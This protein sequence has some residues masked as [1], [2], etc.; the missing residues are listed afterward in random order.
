LFNF[1]MLFLRA[2]DAATGAFTRSTLGRGSDRQ[3]RRLFSHTLNKPRYFNKLTAHL[4][5]AALAANLAACG[6][7]VGRPLVAVDEQPSEGSG[8]SG[9]GV[10]GYCDRVT[11]WPEEWEGLENGAWNLVN[12]LRETGVNCSGEPVVPSPPLLNL[13]PALRCAARLHSEDMVV[14]DFFAH[15]NEDGVDYP[16]RIA[17][18][19]YSAPVYGESIA[20]SNEGFGGFGGQVPWSLFQELRAEECENLVDPRFDSVG[21]G[22]YE[23]V[24]T[25]DFAGR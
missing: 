23:G 17:Q 5:S 7:G 12:E 24:W 14:R 16:E 6:D 4:I 19:G 18:T 21:I 25:L 10:A 22:Y 20:Q 9:G 13:V 8:G 11:S 1:V 15:V 2:R 3:L